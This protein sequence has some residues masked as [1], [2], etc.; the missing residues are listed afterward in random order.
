MVKLAIIGDLHGR[1]SD[2]DVAY[3]NESDYDL[4]LFVG[5]LGGGTA[6]LLARLARPT[7]LIPGNHDGATLPQLAAE[8]FRSPRLAAITG[9]GHGRRLDRLERQLDLVTTAGF[10]V[11]NFAFDQGDLDIVACRPC[12]MGGEF[13]GFAP[14]LKRRYGI[15]SME[16][17]ARRLVA[18]VD[19]CPAENL[20]FLAHNGPTGLGSRRHDIW[21]RDFGRK[22]GDHGDP[23]LRTAIDYAINR[24]G[25]R[26]LAVVAGHMHL[27]VRHGGGRERPW[28]V[29]RDGDGVVYVNAARVPRPWRHH[30]RLEWDGGSVRAEE[31]FA[32][33]DA[34]EGYSSG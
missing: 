27:A 1:F 24:A 20:L 9:V 30:I 12:S 7:V 5:D 21:G 32:L 17:S 3:F 14:L 2:R 28:R 33:R 23:D 34:A 6:P 19:E 8:V 4:L 10:S 26:V 15:A 11:H 22:E 16:E 13:L 31:K 29:E 25:K 18:L